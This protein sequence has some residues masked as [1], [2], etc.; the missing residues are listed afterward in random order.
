MSTPASLEITTGEV[1]QP[2]AT[3]AR[4]S[5]MSRL[6]A[7]DLVAFADIFSVA[8]GAAVPAWIYANFGGLPT[9]W[10]VVMQTALLGG[11]V[12][13][14][15]LRNAGMYDTNQLH[16]LPVHPGRL[17]VGV[18][19][20]IASVLLLGLPVAN[21]QWHI[22]VWY[23]TWLSASFTMIL[24]ARG[25]AQAV[26]AR[27]TRAGRF[28]RRVAVFGAGTVSRRVHDQLS[29]PASGVFFAGVYDDRAGEDRLNPEGLTVAGKFDELLAAAY[30]GEI[31]DIIIALP[32]AADGR[33]AT[34]ARKLE[35]APCNVHIV[36]HIASDLISG[37]GRH[38]VSQIGPVGLLDVKEKPLSD[39]S[40]LVK[41][42]E[43]IIVASFGLAIALPLLA[44]AAIAIKLESKGSII[45]RQR[46]RG[47]NRQVI[48]V[49]KLR[50]MTVTE[51]DSEIR[52]AVE[53]DARITRVGRILRRT[54]IDELPQLWN[55]LKGEMSVV[56]PRPHALVHDEKFSRM[57]EEYANRHQVKPGITGLAQVKGLRGETRTIDRIRDRVEQDMAYV[58]NWSLW[59]DLKIIARTLVIVVTGKNAY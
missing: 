30:A 10:G 11:F 22:L 33:I 53:D 24:A 20:A 43:D 57:L 8:L 15:W 52:Q 48:D 28:D 21:M 45:Y 54:S 16:D 32:Q 49:L 25:I 47:L 44:V 55:V 58:R 1:S 51:D 31:D 39:W 50:T 4:H 34:I 7:I 12:A 37:P 17:F 38:R 5:R 40:P 2:A 9:S 42:A 59:L 18:A 46:R 36:T 3:P 56:G 23:V 26:L 13:Y 14:L 29:D 19:V 27:M 41:R 35:Q 6:V